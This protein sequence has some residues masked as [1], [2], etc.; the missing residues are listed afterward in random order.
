MDEEELISRVR[1]EGGLRN[2]REAR[3]AIGAAIGALRCAMA[4]EDAEAIALELPHS[5][6]KMVAHPAPSRVRSAAALYEE[7]ERRERVGL[8]FA[9]EHSQV[10][11][12]VLAELFQPETLARLRK[13]V[14]ADIAA[15]LRRRA[16]AFQPAPPHVHEHP[17]EAEGARRTLSRGR[18]GPRDSIVEARHLLAHGESVARSDT[19][20]AD[21]SVGTARSTRPGR[22]DETLAAAR[23]RQTPK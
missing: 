22:E 9:L 19:P 5:L 17:A 3:R 8:G 21:R 12:R 1:A 18:P 7:A 10:V 13:R 15:L 23:A 20:H 6:A 14:P 11:L 16:D 2:H 4:Q